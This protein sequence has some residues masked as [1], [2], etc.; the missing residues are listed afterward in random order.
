MREDLSTACQT[1]DEACLHRLP[2]VKLTHTFQLLSNPNPAVVPAASAVLA[3]AHAKVERWAETR[4]AGVIE[5]QIVLA[6]VTE[7]EAIRLREQL[8]AL[9]GVV[10]AKVV[11]HL[12]RAQR[13]NGVPAR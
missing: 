8:A 2:G 1:A 11:H 10:R 13:A 9:D 4:Y 12:V 5:Q 3:N 6:D 7:G